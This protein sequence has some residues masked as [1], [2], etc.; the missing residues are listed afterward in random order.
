MLSYDENDIRL[1]S[2]VLPNVSAQLR[3]TMA[4]LFAAAG[5]IAPPDARDADPELDQN[6]AYLTMSCHRMLRLV[7]N[8]S[9]MS[10]LKD[11][12]APALHNDDIVAFCQELADNVELL[13]ELCGINFRFSCDCTRRTIA[14]NG[15]LLE[16]ALLNLLSNAMKFTPRGGTVE[17]RVACG[18]RFVRII[19]SDTGCGI[20]TDRLDHL[21]DQYLET[22]RIDAYPHGLGLGLALA[23]R[24]A[25]RLGGTITAES[26]E[27]EGSAF[28]LSLPNARTDA[29]ALH[30]ERFDYAGGFD[31]ALMELS[32]ALPASAFTQKYLD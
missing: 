30:E 28:T 4:N 18:E 26:T 32:D 3:S 29:L 7:G 24:I 27:G 15:A 10:E 17:L 14:F 6:A 13:F 2:E 1:L 23:Q 5:R 9:A 25:Q 16:R 8:L 20:P 22:D 31:H 19:V 11:A 12:P 21:F